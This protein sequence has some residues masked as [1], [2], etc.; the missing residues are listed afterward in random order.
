MLT[1]IQIRILLN[2]MG[3]CSILITITLC[4]AFDFCMVRMTA[5]RQ[6]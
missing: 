6:H 2:T 3:E 4:V 5:N 1:L